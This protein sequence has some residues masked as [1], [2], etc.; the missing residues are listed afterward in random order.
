VRMTFD[1]GYLSPV[2]LNC[3]ASARAVAY[4]R[5]VNNDIIMRL[6]NNGARK[7][8]SVLVAPQYLAP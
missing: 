4:T 2:I 1:N 7:C 3:H 8:C 5:V 6:L